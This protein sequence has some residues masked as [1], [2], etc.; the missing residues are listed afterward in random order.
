MRIQAQS[1]HD[2]VGQVFAGY[3]II[4]SG[5]YQG[6]ST[7]LTFPCECV[8]CGSKRTFRATLLYHK[9]RS[10]C[11]TCRA[12]EAYFKE[13]PQCGNEM[14]KAAERCFE[15]NRQRMK[16]RPVNYHEVNLMAVSRSLGIVHKTVYRDVGRH[17]IRKAMEN[18]GL[19]LDDLKKNP[20]FAPFSKGRVRK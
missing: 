1:R 10:K 20:A 11:D 12:E 4:G 19:N 5:F 15:C 7:I 17:G 14:S 9:K 2:R 8:G 13:C 18:Y 3:R 6:N 16:G